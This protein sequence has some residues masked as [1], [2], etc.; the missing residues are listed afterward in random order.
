[1]KRFLYE[2]H[3]NEGSKFKKETYSYGRTNITLC[4]QENKA[5]L[6]F[7]LSV[8]KKHKDFTDFSVKLFDDAYRKIHL[9]HT[10]KY[11]KDIKVNTITISINNETVTYGREDKHFPYMFSMIGKNLNLS[12]E[13]S[14]VSKHIL[15]DSK[16]KQ[17]DDLRY[18]AM[19]SYLSAISRK[20]EIDSFTNLWTAMNSYYTY[21]SS[22]HNESIEACDN[23]NINRKKINLSRERDKIDYLTTQIDPL[24]QPPSNFKDIPWKK[25]YAAERE[26]VKIIKEEYSDLYEF[27]LT[28][29]Y[30]N[31]IPDRYR[32]ITEY[33]KHSGRSLFSYLLLGYPYYLRCKYFHG[34]HT[35]VLLAAYNEYELAVL[36]LINYFLR[37]YLNKAIPQM[38]EDDDRDEEA[39]ETKQ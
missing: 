38:F 15:A 4:L 18:A 29:P 30:S 37:R 32:K 20:N 35:T 16:S 21:L 6:F 13:W 12:S 14:I 26:L 10:I 8:L 28:S 2:I 39:I 33:A 7:E 9:L 24:Y 11:S 36:G 25:H 19:F 34:E 5:S 27:A 22:K 1:M 17:T 31:N 3:F 23:N